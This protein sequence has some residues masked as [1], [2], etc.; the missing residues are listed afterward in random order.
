MF[1]EFPVHFHV[2]PERS[3]IFFLSSYLLLRFLF[4]R[5][6]SPFELPPVSRVFLYPGICPNQAPSSRSLI[7]KLKKKGGW[8]GALLCPL[9]SLKAYFSIG[10]EVFDPP[11]RNSHRSRFCP[12]R[13]RCFTRFTPDLFAFISPPRFASQTLECRV[14][15][16]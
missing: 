1:K 6:G 5:G 10:P 15:D 16:P 7:P 8:F 11:P 14:C 2:R 12:V 3:R 9:T 13:S 4:F